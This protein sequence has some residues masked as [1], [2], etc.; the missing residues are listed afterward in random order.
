MPLPPLTGR[1]G[2]PV[3]HL[4]ADGKRLCSQVADGRDVE[5]HLRVYDAATGADIDRLVDTNPA[6][7]RK[8]PNQSP[9]AD[10]GAH[11][12][13]TSPGSARTAFTLIELL[14]VIAIIAVLI[15][16]LVP[17]VQTVR[18][19]ANRVQCA[20][21]LKQIGL[22]FHAHRSNNGRFPGGGWG[23]AWVG[24]PDR[25]PGPSQPGGWAY[26]ILPHL[27][28]DNL[29]RLPGD[30]KPDVITPAQLA[31]AASAQQVPLPL[32]YCPSRRRAV[33]YPCANPSRVNADNVGQCGKSDYGA[34][35]GDRYVFWGR[36]PA[37]L[38][39]ALN[40][41][42]FSDMTQATGISFQRSALLMTDIPDGASNTYLAGEKYLNPDT[43][44][45]G[46]S[47]NDN[48]CCLTGDDYDLHCW[49]AD[50]PLRDTRGLDRPGTYGSAHSSGFN[51]VLADGSVRYVS[52][53]ISP[54]T[55]ALLANRKD[56]Q[57]VPEF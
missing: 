57:P 12:V 36:G 52:Y 13:T 55:H 22:A 6:N 51:V 44:T 2:E 37:S 45:I 30:G 16:L 32:L 3:Y 26:Q 7:D 4:S 8:C 43:Y 47:I 21:N 54:T 31:G 5:G 14:V 17:A 29:Y 1:T 27:E 25:G 24:D 28:Q 40:G 9:P 23:W 33:A 35:G 48:E 11:S 41:V 20:N 42:G 49:A 15:G 38:A 46:S 53:S 50:P 39:G 34:N 18:E 19:A 10:K 56:G